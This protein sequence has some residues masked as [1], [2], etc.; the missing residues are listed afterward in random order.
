MQ[1]RYLFKIAQGK[2]QLVEKISQKQTADVTLTGDVEVIRKI[3][4]KQLKTDDG[5]M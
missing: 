3:L 5:S 2:L 4:D 1:T